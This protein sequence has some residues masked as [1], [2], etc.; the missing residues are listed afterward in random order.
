MHI[1][2]NTPRWAL[3][4]L[5]PVRYKGAKGGRGSGKSHFFAEQVVD[6]SISERCDIICIREKQ[7]S[8][9]FSAKKLIESKIRELGVLHLFDIQDKIIKNIYGNIIIFEGMANH[10]ADSIKSLDGFKYAWVEEAQSLSQRSIDL[11]TPTIRM[12]DSEIWFSWNP[13]EETDAIEQ[14]LCGEKPPENSIVCHVNFTENPWFPDTLRQD[15]EYMRGRDPDKYAH[16]WLGEYVQNS[17]ARVFK[18]WRIEEFE[19]P[20][21]TVHRLGA[22]WGF[23]VD[24]TVLLRCHI[25]GKN[26]YIDYEAYRVGCEIVDI[27]DLFMEIPDAEKFPMTADSAR[28]ET[29]S[30]LRKNGFPKISPAVKGARSL[31]EGV[32]WLQSF[33][34]IVHPR[35]QHVIDELSTYSFKVDDATDK[36]LPVLE[37]KNNHLIDALR[38]ACEGVR[39]AESS[40]NKPKTKVLPIKNFW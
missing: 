13:Y 31:E 35:C 28:P 29:I 2:I 25:I 17:E 16:I 20:A 37:D 30:H 4:F 19:A 26:L 21:G 6:K 10:T 18:H 14:L 15:M 22:D 12:P 33:D 24:P 7:K 39:R 11:L 8:L 40:K 23:S 1:E 3:P 36:V 9:K 32:S 27:P 5:Q 38:Y 34:I